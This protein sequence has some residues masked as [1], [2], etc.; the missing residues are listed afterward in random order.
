MEILNLPKST[1][2]YST[3]L[4][5]SLVL[6]FWGEGWDRITIHI[7]NSCFHFLMVTVPEL[8]RKIVVLPIGEAIIFAHPIK[9]PCLPRAITVTIIIRFPSAQSFTNWAPSNFCLV[10]HLT[11]A[12]LN[13]LSTKS[14]Y[15]LLHLENS[16][17]LPEVW[18]HL[19]IYKYTYSNMI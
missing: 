10:L 7:R 19:D 1:V 2:Q 12:P 8:S 5:N 16:L 4:P 3:L 9:S 6:K 13:S 18:L 14:L 11:K 17:G 15:N